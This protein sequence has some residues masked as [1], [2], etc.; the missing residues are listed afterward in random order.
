M[1]HFK[2][3]IGIISFFL[4]IFCFSSTS[5]SAEKFNVNYD[6]AVD[7]T[8]SASEMIVDGY[9][10]KVDITR[11]AVPFREITFKINV[12]NDSKPVELSSG[13]MMFNMAMDMGLYK[14]ELQKVSKGYIAKVTLP[15][16]IFGG[17]RWYGKLVFTAAG[18]EHQKIYIFDMKN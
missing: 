16:C 7:V 14:S 6:K 9:N 18:Q 5:F 11:P 3:V 17:T 4:A 12:Y 8:N 13:Y 15:K 2:H 1:V 10:V